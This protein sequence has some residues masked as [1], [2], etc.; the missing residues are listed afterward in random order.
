MAA[1]G[2]WWTRVESC[3]EVILAMSRRRQGTAVK[4]GREKKR[5]M[6]G[7]MRRSMDH[8]K[9][10]TQFTKYPQPHTPLSAGSR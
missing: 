10:R 2:G 9:R 5:R 7:S 1:H 3:L 4:G 8:N 6:I